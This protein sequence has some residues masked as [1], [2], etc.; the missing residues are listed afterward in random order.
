MQEV[1]DY[2]S[3]SSENP[4]KGNKTGMGIENVDV[5][6]VETLPPPEKFSVPSTEVSVQRS[7][8]P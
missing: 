3:T 5:I 4:F 7:S 1:L 8:W 2:A 6:I